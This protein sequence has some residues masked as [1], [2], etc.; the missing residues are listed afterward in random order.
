[1]NETDM[2][3]DEVYIVHASHGN[4]WA[5]DTCIIDERTPIIQTDQTVLFRSFDI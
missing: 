3:V 5:E 4:A 2:K 1:M